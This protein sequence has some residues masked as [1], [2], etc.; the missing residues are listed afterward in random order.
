MAAPWLIVMLGLGGGAIE[1]DIDTFRY[2]RVEAARGAWQ[3]S[4]GAPAVQ[5]GGADGKAGMVQPIPFAADRQL[6]RTILDR[7]TELDLTSAGGFV[8][9]LSVDAAESPGQLSL[10]FRSG[11]GWYAAGR[12][13]KTGS[14][15]LHFSRSSFNPEGNPAGWQQID[16]IRL[17]VWRTANV[18]G[19]VR[20]ERLFAVEHEVALV[21]PDASGGDGEVR[22]EPDV[23]RGAAHRNHD[24]GAGQVAFPTHPHP[25]SFSNLRF[26]TRPLSTRSPSTAPALS[27]WI[28]TR[29]RKLGAWKTSGS[30]GVSSK[31]PWRRCRPLRVPS[32]T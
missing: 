12:G 28:R 13:L 15:S 22:A 3:A 31:S 17:S 2:A 29:P 1:T 9:Q 14:Q 26:R 11:D 6:P 4:S 24:T 23:L 8:L 5:P 25:S 19:R 16:G 32:S 7:R 18:D 21:V 27:R 30:T 10:Y 20:F